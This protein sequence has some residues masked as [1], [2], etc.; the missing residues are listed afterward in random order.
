MIGILGATAIVAVDG[1]VVS[2]VGQPEA[3]GERATATRLWRPDR[4]SG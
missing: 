3:N 4:R 2:Q 1:M